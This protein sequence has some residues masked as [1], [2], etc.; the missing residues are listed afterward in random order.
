MGHI[1]LPEVIIVL[2]LVLM[3]A[4]IIRIGVWLVRLLINNNQKASNPIDIARERYAK[5]EIS[6]ADFEDIK[7]NIP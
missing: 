2:I 3:S 4:A 1:G 5:G 7:S 6:K